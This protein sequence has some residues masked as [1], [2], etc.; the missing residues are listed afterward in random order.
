[1][2]DHRS[3][4]ENQ[5]A[6]RST[7]H[8][9]VAAL[10]FALDLTEKAVPGHALRSCLLATRLG[11]ALGL[12]SS[13]LGDLYY[14]ANLKD[15]GCSSNAARMC[16]I[17][18]GD[19]RV[20]KAETKLMN[21]RKRQLPASAMFQTMWSNTLPGA[22]AWK[23]LIRLLTIS[24]RQSETAEELIALRCDRGAGIVRQI[25]LGE[26]V[27]TAVRHLDEHWDGGSYPSRLRGAEIPILSRLMC[28][29]QTLDVFCTSQGPDAAIRTAR[30]R[31]GRWFDPDLVRAAE[32]LHR[33]GTLWGACLPGEPA[34]AT[35]AAVL[36]LEP[37]AGVIPE[38]TRLEAICDAFAGVVD[39]KSPFT[40]R[41]SHGVKDAA[42]AIGRA[43]GLPEP[44]IT[45]LR[46]AALLHD[47]GKLSVPNTILDKP[48]RLTA[49]EF[50]VVREHSWLSRQILEKVG[51]FSEIATVAGDH[52]ER[53]DGSGYPNG[54]AGTMLPLESRLLAVADV[55]GALTEKRPYREALAPKAVAAI[56]D[57]DV[58][59]KLDA[60]C[61]EA[62]RADMMYG[63]METSSASA[64]MV[65][66]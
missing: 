46:R 27:A 1:M 58:P 10:S 5:Q 43:M 25:G 17:I 45:M 3:S 44:R 60:Q 51:V 8:E 66:A 54:V 9:I 18:G 2:A 4:Q 14:A 28:L 62:L 22:S 33:E 20:M 34:S 57:K 65:S 41:H 30:E 16:Q 50:G 52:H 13:A 6:G 32:L 12:P 61:Y 37:D 15:V 64:E 42:V 7:L 26:G 11:S 23:K 40:F 53:L 47:I 24:A 39:A 21:W 56:M 36:A 63:R 29:A 35:H 55:Y 59:A 48:G 31:S 19:D 49:E 38:E